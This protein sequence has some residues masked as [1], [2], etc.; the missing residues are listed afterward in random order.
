MCDID[1]R[2]L[3]VPCLGSD[4]VAQYMID[5]TTGAFTANPIAARLAVQAGCGPRQLAL[6][7][8]GKWMYLLCELG[9]LLVTLDYDAT[10]GIMLMHISP[11]CLP[12]DRR[13]CSI[14]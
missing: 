11:A 6:H 1:A 13:F 8:N 7:P 4:Y 9:S 2:Y 12:I 5:A 3:F 14:P 10:T